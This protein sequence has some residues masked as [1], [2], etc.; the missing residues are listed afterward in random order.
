[1]AGASTNRRAELAR[2]RQPNVPG[3]RP[4]K[5]IVK[6]S[7]AEHAA[8]T[9]RAE[10]AGMTIPRLLVETVLHETGSETGRAH[11]ALQLLDLENQIRRVGN[12]LN[13][14]VRY[15]HQNKEI[16]E[17]TDM[18]LRSV[19]RAC[20]SLDETARWVM[21]KAP[22][23]SE[24]SVSPEVDLAVDEEWAAAIDGEE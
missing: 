16:A 2:E 10:A 20:L 18:A 3:G 4:H 22:A 12:N 8:L 7:A 15:A 19:I 5:S 11:A 24:I 1:M 9:A 13:Q 17:G 21:G 6:L 14:L 23:M